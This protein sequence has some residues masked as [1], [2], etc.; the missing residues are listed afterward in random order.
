[1]QM[2][3]TIVLVL[4]LRR[5]VLLDR[6][7]IGAGSISVCMV[8]SLGAGGSSNVDSGLLAGT[9][10]PPYHKAKMRRNGKP[11]DNA[12]GTAVAK[13]SPFV[14]VLS[15]AIWLGFNGADSLNLP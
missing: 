3:T 12:D 2:P 10:T 5:V 7:V 14:T 4:G 6:V 15:N 9:E 13:C 1:M 11:D 8:L